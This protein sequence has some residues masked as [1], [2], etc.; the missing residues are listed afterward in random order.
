MATAYWE[1]PG[2]AKDFTH[3]VP[4]ELVAERLDPRARILDFGCGYGRAMRELARAGYRNCVGVDPSAALIAR[5]RREAPGLRLE[6]TPHL[7][8][9]YPAG[10]FAA[11]LLISV[12]AV[13]PENDAQRRVAAEVERVCAPG[14][15]VFLCDYPLQEGE[16]YRTAYAAS[17]HPLHGVFETP[18]GGVFRHHDPDHLASLFPRLDLVQARET[19]STSLSGHPMRVLQW[20]LRRGGSEPP[21]WPHQ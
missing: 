3:P 12:L 17:A 11:V 8:L 1:G 16:R 9:D 2:A 14:G 19:E 20:T 21:W 5:G 7:P 4:T 6:H 15:L 10:A 18:D 13:I